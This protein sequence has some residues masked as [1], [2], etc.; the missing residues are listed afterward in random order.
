MSSNKIWYISKYA[1]I[2]AKGGPARQYLFSK[3]FALKG[4]KTILISSNSNGF[5]YLNFNDEYAL[6]EKPLFKHYVLKGPKIN[7][8]FNIKRIYTWFLFEYRLLK[9]LKKQHISKGDTVIVSSLSILTFRSGVRLKKKY[10]INLIIEVRDIWPQSL[11]ELK[12]LSKKNPFV[13]V[14]S[15]IEKKAYKNA[16]FIVGSMGNLGEHIKLVAPGNEHKFRYI[17]MG[18]DPEVLGKTEVKINLE[19]QDFIVGYAG[20]IG[21]ANKIDLILDAA[22]IL[23]D[24]SNI[25]FKILGDGVLK[26]QFMEKYSHLKNVEFLPSVEKSKVN[27]FLQSCHILL[28]PWEDKPIYNYGVSPNKWIDYMYAERPIIIPF[29]GFKNIINEADCGEFIEANNPELFAKT[30]LKYSNLPKK[31]LLAMGKRGKKY[32]EDNLTYEKLSNL[33][34]EL[35]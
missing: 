19:S 17:P 23:K 32:L 3:H 7:L 12:N 30:I 21:I 29:N 26:T 9:F 25:K 11:I 5:Q 27:S 14:L 28:N 10:D 22:Y 33:Y 4:F 2:P 1:G 35:F 18:L 20:S 15:S 34:I 31:E 16:D 6:F 8:G 13:H 24:I